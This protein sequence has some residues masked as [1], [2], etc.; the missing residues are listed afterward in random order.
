MQAAMYLRKSRAEEL[1][2]PTEDT[3]AKHKAKLLEYAKSHD[4]TIVKIY[5][6]VVSGE[7]L[8]AR[9]QMLELLQNVGEGAYDAVLVM[10]IARLGRGGMADQGII[11]DTF[12]ASRTKII[13]PAK[14]YDLNN[15]LDEEY[16]EFETFMSRRELKTIKRRLRL[17]LE[18]SIKQGAYVANAPYGYEKT[19]INKM[20]TLAI[21]ESEARF[22]RMI[23]DMY[24]NQRVGCLSI[25]RYIS[26]LGAVPKRGGSFGSS[27]IRKI[28][29]NQTYLG[30]VVWNKV[31]YQKKNE[32]GSVRSSVQINDEK[33][34]IVADGLHPAIIDE[35]TFNAAQEIMKRHYNPA[36][37]KYKGY[38]ETNP[39]SGLL[40]C[41]KCGHTM[42]VRYFQKVHRYYVLCIQPGCCKST[43]LSY[44]EDAILSYLESSLEQLQVPSTI[45]KKADTIQPMIQAVQRDLSSAISQKDRLYDLL[46]QGVYDVDTF[47]SRSR[48][49]SEKIQKLE[50]SLTELQDRQKEQSEDKTKRLA[51]N[52][53]TVLQTYRDSS[54]REKNILLKSVIDTAVYYKDKSMKTSEFE[55]DITLKM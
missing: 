41:R 12:K 22:V 35:D 9:P 36:V 19:I 34:W 5:E 29:M 33:D 13:T 42:Q 4:I 50:N 39:F 31:H 11:L 37:P 26:G 48:T 15:D 30:K 1:S 24:V 54:P 53:Q 27:A 43:P 28:L 25:G 20:P 52:I 8:Y 21:N 17:G 38:V 3:V 16:T 10:E 32:N 23:F 14:T 6:E 46:E 2:Q 40:T 18:Q 47:T 45:Q 49:L 55:L 44:V 51:E 7:Y